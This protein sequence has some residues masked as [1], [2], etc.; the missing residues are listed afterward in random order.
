MLFR[1]KLFWNYLEI[2]LYNLCIYCR[3]IYWEIYNI[4]R[5]FLKICKNYTIYAQRIIL[6]GSPGSC[7]VSWLPLPY[8]DIAKFLITVIHLLLFQCN[9]QNSTKIRYKDLDSVV[10]LG[11]NICYYM[12][13]GYRKISLSWLISQYLPYKNI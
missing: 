11:K 10:S 5:Y 12:N 1:E 8:I 9:R 13:R 6:N 2:N 3:E 7:L 4:F